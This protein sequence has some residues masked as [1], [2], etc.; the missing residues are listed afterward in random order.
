MNG[1]VS[2]SGWK[3]EDGEV[4]LVFLEAVLRGRAGFLSLSVLIGGRLGR[5]ASTLL[6]LAVNGEGFFSWFLVLVQNEE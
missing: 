6:Y 3:W 4:G 2:A 1:S 5:F